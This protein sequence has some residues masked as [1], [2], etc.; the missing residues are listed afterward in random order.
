MDLWIQSKEDGIGLHSIAHWVLIQQLCPTD[1]FARLCLAVGLVCRLWPGRARPCPPIRCRC[2]RN[3]FLRQSSQNC[4]IAC[5]LLVGCAI[6][7][8][9]PRKPTPT[10]SCVSSASTTSGTG[11]RWCSPDQRFPH[12]PGCR[13]AG[14]RRDS[15]SGLRAF[16][17]FIVRCSRLIP[18][19]SGRDPGPAAQTPPGGVNARGDRPRAG[20]VDRFVSPDCA[21]VIRFRTAPAGSF[22]SADSGPGFRPPRDSRSPWEGR[23]GPADHAAV[24]SR[25]CPAVSPGGCA[26]AAPKGT[27]RRVAARSVC[28]RPSS[29]RCPRPAPMALAM[30]V[31]LVDDL[32]RSARAG[33]GGIIFTKERCPVRSARLAAGPD[34]EQFPPF[35]CHPPA[36]GGL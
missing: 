18:A 20:R 10:G 11:W 28:P 5:V 29:V 6:T 30:G 34:R 23:Q 32:G 27:G 33:A 9:A 22:A 16:C 7:V 13:G 12:P 15:E 14:Q 8:C 2:R 35:V 24:G 36:R 26:P 21:V 4:W 31:S 1:T 25:A 19:R 3:L 17:S